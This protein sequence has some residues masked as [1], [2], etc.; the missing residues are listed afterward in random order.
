MGCLGNTSLGS[1]YQPDQISSFLHI[2]TYFP[3]NCVRRSAIFFYQLSMSSSCNRN[4]QRKHLRDHYMASVDECRCHSHISKFVPLWAD[5]VI[6]PVSMGKYGYEQL[7]S[8]L[9]PVVRITGSVS[10]D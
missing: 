1:T 3:P 7:S 4:D 5:S 8:G 6:D 10:M 9:A 2:S